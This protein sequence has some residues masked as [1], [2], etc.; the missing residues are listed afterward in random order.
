[1]FCIQSFTFHNL[2]VLR[3]NLNTILPDSELFNDA[4]KKIIQKHAQSSASRIFI[5]NK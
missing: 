1:M 2:K 5:E 3:Y 4:Q